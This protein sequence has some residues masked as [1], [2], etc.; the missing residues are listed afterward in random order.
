MAKNVIVVSGATGSV[1]REVV[2]QL[3]DARASVRAL[4]R[5][6]DSADLPAAVDVARADLSDAASLTGALADA[7]NVFLVWPFTS[8][9][10]ATEIAP[11]VVETIARAAQRIVYLSAEAAERKLDSFWATLERLVE[12]SAA[13][14]TF[15]RPTGFAKNTL[16]WADQIR[17]TG[18]VRWPYAAA[19][20]SL[21][22]E[23][24]VAAV[25]ARALTEDRHRSATYVLSGP[26]TLTQTEQVQ[27][28][29]EA[30]GRPLHFEEISPQDVRPAL[31][32]A[33]GDESFADSA[34]Q[35]LAGFVEQ[36]ERTT[37]VAEE[38]TGRPAHT[39]IEW[40][41]HHSADFL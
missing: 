41:H 22:D 23:R 26:A 35:T 9:Q 34:L 36:P 14:W 20:R 32:E 6:P 40:A 24:D 13:E 11:A 37:S 21:I 30:I 16:M 38:V 12:R 25:A 8:P 18:I 29:G 4:V 27:A 39:F 3:L 17:T 33:L 1:G 31:A 15:L 7:Q 19:A 2:S 5:D 28:I 10:A